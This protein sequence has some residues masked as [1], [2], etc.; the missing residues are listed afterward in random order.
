M[1][2][3]I[4]NPGIHSNSVNDSCSD[5][6]PLQT[7]LRNDPPQDQ[8]KSQSQ[9]PDLSW[10][11]DST[12]KTGLGSDATCDPVQAGTTFN[13][14]KN[15]D[16]SHIYRNTQVIRACNEAMIDMFSNINV[17]DENGKAHKIPIMLATQ[18]RAVA[19][20]LQDNIRKDNL[21]VEQIKLPLLALHHT[22][23][24]LDQTRYIY[25]KAKDYMRYLRPDKKPGFT[26]NTKYNRS[27]VFGISKGVPINIGF[28]LLAWTMYL[29]D[30]DQIIEQIMLKSFPMSY[31]NVRGVNWE[32]TV[33]LDSIGNNIDF[34]PGDENKRII[35][36]E[37]NFNVQT[38][39]PQPI[40]KTKSVLKTKTDIYNSVED[41]EITDVYSRIEESAKELENN[42]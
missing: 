11:E 10:L 2:K 15:P 22:D 38:Y 3:E 14:P 37:F 40:Y 29:Y 1:G 20:I 16:K 30:M 36:Y 13:D 41:E 25:H 31:I 5:I 26:E 12:K 33:I 4:N 21:V 27:N 8:C 23:I 24:Q 17:Q 7:P 42:D 35:K 9:E 19:Y 18:E 32:S 6:P 34:Q 28:N 39:I